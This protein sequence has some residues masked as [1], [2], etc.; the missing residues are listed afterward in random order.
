MPNSKWLCLEPIIFQIHFTSMNIEQS[1][2]CVK[3][4]VEVFN[5]GLSSSPSVGRYCSSVLPPDLTSMSHELRVQFHS[6]ADV[7]ASGF[8]M[9]YEFVENGNRLIW[10]LL[11]Y[12]PYCNHLIWYINLINQYFN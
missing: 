4:F 6:D 8:R 7:D 3:D 12:V 1:N 9:Q 2:N 10:L 11:C 5:G